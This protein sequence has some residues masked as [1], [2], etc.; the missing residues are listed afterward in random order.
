MAGSGDSAGNREEGSG[1]VGVWEEETVG[2]LGFGRE[3][4][5]VWV[6][7]DP[8]ARGGGDEGFGEKGESS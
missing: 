4:G 7:S 1:L 2:D 5:K 3:G 6:G 8:R